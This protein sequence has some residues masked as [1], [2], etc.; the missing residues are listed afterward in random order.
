MMSKVTTFSHEDILECH[1]HAVMAQ[2]A[3]LDGKE[4]KPRFK[5][6]NWST[7]KFLDHDGAQC[8]IVSNKT[9]VAVAFRGTEPAEF[10]DLLADLNAWPD[11]PMIG[12]GKVH[13][14]F[15]NELEKLWPMI[16]EG[17][18]PHLGKKLTL[19]GHSLGGAMATVAASRFS[20]DIGVD[21]LF[22]YGSPRTGTSDFVKAFKHVPHFRFVNNN[23]IVP[24]V[25]LA[26]MGYRHHCGPMYIDF[27][28]NVHAGLSWGARFRDKMKG[29][30]A[31]LKKGQ[32]FDN[33]FDHSSNY[34]AQ[35]T[36]EEA[37]VRRNV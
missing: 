4:A 37:D 13:N 27:K 5:A 33:F 24:T 26:I 8:H 15:Q 16:L 11:K 25:P 18:T 10:S 20:M 17:L 29:R 3:Y 7:H 21:T 14:G 2:A 28:G 23:D 34:Y 19:C 35:Y 32:P 36:G 30:W 22:T 12:H 1:R 6:L 31:A 9:E